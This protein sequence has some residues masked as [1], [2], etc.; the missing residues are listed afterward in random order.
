MV[1][2][3]FTN[4]YNQLKK[5]QI[6]WI[7]LNFKER[8]MAIVKY[9]RLYTEYI[10]LVYELLEYNYKDYETQIF[11]IDIELLEFEKCKKRFYQTMRIVLEEKGVG[12]NKYI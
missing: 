10:N 8:C 5:L 2:G 12:R 4:I 9:H 1:Y 6:D 7:S 11:I 3:I